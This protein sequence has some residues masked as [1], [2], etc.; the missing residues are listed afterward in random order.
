LLAV[1][2]GAGCATPGGGL[3]GLG[4]HIAPA[5]R[6]RGLDYA[7]VYLMGE[8][9]DQNLGGGTVVISENAKGFD[10]LVRVISVNTRVEFKN[11]DRVFH[12]AFSVSPAKPFDV[13]SFPPGQRRAVVFDH[14][15]VI[16]VY[17]ELHP[18]AAALLVVVP[19]RYFARVDSDGGFR[20]GHVPPGDYKLVAWHPDLGEINRDVHVPARGTLRLDLSY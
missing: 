19:T 16:Q 2:L 20:L 9:T 12:N 3:G 15:G 13:G 5:A 7:V 1:G 4:G 11:R 6:G 17:C 14:P 10:P 8:T 18:A